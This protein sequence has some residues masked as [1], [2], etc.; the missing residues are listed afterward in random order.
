MIDPDPAP[1][2][3]FIDPLDAE[4]IIVPA[5]DGELITIDLDDYLTDPNGDPLT[6]TPGT[7]PAGATFNPATNELTFIPT[8]DNN[9]DTVVP[10]SATDNNGG[11]IAP[12]VT[13]QPVNPGPDAINQT[14]VTTPD[15]PVDIDPLA[16][17][18]DPDND[19]LTITE[20][21]GVTL[22]PGT[23]QTIPVANGTVS[24]AVDGT[25]T[26]TPNTGFAG[27]IDVPYSIVDQDGAT[28]TAIHS[29][30][31]GNAPPEVIDPDPASG[32]PSIDPADADNIIIPAVDGQPV[33]IDLDDYLTDPNGDTLT[34]TPGT[35]PAGATFDPATNELTFVPTVDNTGDTVIPFTVDDGNGGTTAPTVTIQP[36]NPLPAAVDETVSTAFET[37]VVID[38][39]ANDIDPDADPL[40]ITQINGVALTQGIAQTIT[41]SNGS[42]TV[43][44][45]GTVTVTPSNG[46]SGVI[47]VPYSIVDQDGAIDSAVH[48]VE[49]PNAPPEVIDPDPTP[50]TP[51]IDP[52]DAENIIVPAIDGTPVTIDLDDYLTDPNGDPLT[53]TPGTLPSGA[54]FNPATNEVTFIPPV[55]NDGDTVV[56]FSV[57][58]SN[59]G[60]ITP[61]VT[62]QPVNPG[63]DAVNQTVSTA[64][65]TPIAIDPLANDTDP[66]NDPLTITEINGVL[67]TPGAA[68]TIPVPNG[69][70]TVAADGTITVTPDAGFAS[71]IDVPYTIVD[72]DGATDNAVHT[73]VVGNAPPEVIDPDPTPGTPFVDPADPENIIVPAVDGTPVTI[74]LDDYLTCLLYTSPS[75]R[76]RG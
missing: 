61:T 16:N 8:V 64:P 35:M 63:P 43:A 10:F 26:V 24:V 54:T 11:T 15:T 23:A 25:I 30:V 45:D 18:S 2:T 39:L 55:D 74:D 66:D 7:L 76:D 6:V 9:G 71:D 51:S 12:T 34:I 14:V 20:I 57:T 19:P 37:A 52:L 68:Q 67:L 27:D 36:V 50:D 40:T 73:V 46:Y 42:V 58:D 17:D 33:T 49:V 62:F 75:P 21:N 47:V 56:P 29:V 72:Q 22:T 65:A 3:P 13:I 1:G 69:T 38:P 59:G 44:A 70:V 31:T 48:I 60:T 28:D 5:V 41:V 4:N 53:I 32:T